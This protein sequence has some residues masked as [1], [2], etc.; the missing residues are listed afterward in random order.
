MFPSV[1]SL[2]QA[3]AAPLVNA[4]EEDCFCCEFSS[5]NGLRAAAVLLGCLKESRKFP[6]SAALCSCIPSSTAEQK[7]ILE[8]AV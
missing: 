1:V 6:R 7:S 4:I 5:A 3:W 2:L 8:A